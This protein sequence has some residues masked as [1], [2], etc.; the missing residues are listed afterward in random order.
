M[1]SPYIKEPT[2][3]TFPLVKLNLG[4]LRNNLPDNKKNMTGKC[5]SFKDSDLRLE[6][7]ARFK[8]D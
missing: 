5:A 6:K 4:F 2:T 8:A 7:Q 1:E 3:I